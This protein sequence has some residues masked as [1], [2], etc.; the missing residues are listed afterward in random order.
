MKKFIRPL[1]LALTVL[2]GSAGAASAQWTRIDSTRPGTRVWYNSN[3]PS[4]I[5]EENSN[6]WQPRGSV[7]DLK[8]RYENLFIKTGNQTLA[9][10]EAVYVHPVDPDFVQ[11]GGK[12]VGMKDIVNSGLA[13]TI[14][15]VGAAGNIVA[16][17]AAGNIVAVG[18]AGNIVAVGA[19][20]NIGSLQS[21]GGFT[22]LNSQS[23]IRQVQPRGT[24][25][26]LGGIGS[27]RRT[28]S[29]SSWIG[30]KKV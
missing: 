17:G 2:F 24:I 26:N 10:G 27:I 20:G 5:Y 28:L 15:G 3:Y 12:W 18:A 21:G 30:A 9:N 22:F 11:R 6:K 25:Q 23:V 16:V 4:Y 13:S 7:Y 1:I 14:V 8:L 29:N 19:A